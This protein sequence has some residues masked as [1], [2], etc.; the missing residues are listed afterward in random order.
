MTT[1]RPIQVIMR[2]CP[3]SAT[4]LCGGGRPDWFSKEKI[5]QNLVATKD[6]QTHITVLFD[7]EMATHWINKYPV[8]KVEIH[9]RSGDASF[10]IQLQYILE[11]QYSDDTIIYIY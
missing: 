9:A 3:D 5:F 2:M 1:P 4:P 11:K 7:G 6:D 10:I 8:E